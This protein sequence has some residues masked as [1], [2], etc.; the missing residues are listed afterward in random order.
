MEYEAH[1]RPGGWVLEQARHHERR[2]L[3]VLA[4]ATAV[5][6]TVAIL[7]FGHVLSFVSGAILLGV[8][9]FLRSIANHA[10]ADW[11]RWRR[12]GLVEEHVGRLL[13]E[14][15]S[16]GCTVLHDVRDPRGGNFDHIVNGPFGVFVIETKAGGWAS[17]EQLGKIAH[18]AK[19][20]KEELEARWVTPVICLHA[21]RGGITKNGVVSIVPASQLVDWIRAQRNAPADRERLR[22]L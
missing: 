22:R 15:R 6:F 11:S 18:Q 19:R 7:A 3:G 10:I 4:L 12:G 20:L 14:L 9:L 2:I 13:D 1:D 8:L 17:T 16:D 21:R 5:V